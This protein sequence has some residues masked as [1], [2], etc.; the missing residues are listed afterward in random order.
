V[1]VVLLQGRRK[2]F[3]TGIIP[4]YSEGLEYLHARWLT[5]GC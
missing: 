5:W 1:D 2:H 3:V 4:G